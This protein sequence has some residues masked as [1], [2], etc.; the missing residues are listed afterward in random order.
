MYM[1]AIENRKYGRI[2]TT[3]AFL[4]VM[5]LLPYLVHLF[6]A[7]A[8]VPMGARLLPLFLAPFL[9]VVLFDVQIA[10]V[11][12]LF[13]PILNHYVVGQ[14]TGGMVVLLTIEALVLCVVAA[15]MYRFRPNFVFTAPLSY[16]VAVLAG[17]LTLAIWPLLPASP[18]SFLSNTLT[19][20]LPGLVLLL[21]LNVGLVRFVSERRL[22]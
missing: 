22:G 11:A 17:T 13:A 8:G 21:I 20:A 19:N 5:V 4:A 10:L 7:H 18:L 3:F 1:H 14:P 16:I 6:P 2:T 9:A 15:A 12:A